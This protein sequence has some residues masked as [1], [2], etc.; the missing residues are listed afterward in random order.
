MTDA[1]R[2][3]TI[4]R[5]CAHGHPVITYTVRRENPTPCPVCSAKGKA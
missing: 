4:V 2:T 5:V 3:A 1:W